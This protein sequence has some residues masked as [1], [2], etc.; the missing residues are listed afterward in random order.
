MSPARIIVYVVKTAT[1]G[2]VWALGYQIISHAYEKLR[3]WIERG[4]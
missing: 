1:D 4:K 2:A 3:E